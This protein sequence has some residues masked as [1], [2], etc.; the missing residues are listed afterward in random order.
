MVFARYMNRTI[1]YV[2]AG[3]VPVGINTKVW[4]RRPIPIHALLTEPGGLLFHLFFRKIL[5]FFRKE[6]Y[7]EGSRLGGTLNLR[8]TLTK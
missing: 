3:P 5:E 7:G 1:C 6:E 8:R 2:N 4:D